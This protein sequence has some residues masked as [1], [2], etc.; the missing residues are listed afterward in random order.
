MPTEVTT[1]HYLC[2]LIFSSDH[3]CTDVYCTSAENRNEIDLLCN[4]V[5]VL[6]NQVFY[7]DYIAFH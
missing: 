5:I 1:S 6:L 2:I 4:C 7:L 3:V